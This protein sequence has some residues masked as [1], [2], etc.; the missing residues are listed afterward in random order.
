LPQGVRIALVP[1]VS[2]AE[3]STA[4]KGARLGLKQSSN[5]VLMVAP[6]AFG[7]N[8]QA[9]QVGCCCCCCCWLYAAVVPR[10]M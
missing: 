8:E 10:C 7:F 1:D 5:E 3:A 9:A 4:A 2:K 6:T